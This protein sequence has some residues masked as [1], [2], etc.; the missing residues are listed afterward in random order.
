LDLGE[1]LDRGFRL[2]WKTIATTFPWLLLIVLPAQIVSV[3]VNRRP[4]GFQ[5]WSKNFQE[6]SQ[7]SPGSPPD[8]SGLNTALLSL[9]PLLLMALI[10]NLFAQGML[11]AFYTDR[12]LLR[13]TPIATCMRSIIGRLLPLAGV[14]LLSGLAGVAGIFMCCI[15]IFFFMT[16]L[17]VASQVCVVERAGAVQSLRR[18]WSLTEKRFWLM[19][20]LV[21]VTSLI[22]Q[23]VNV[24]FS[25][26]GTGIGGALSGVAGDII[27][28][29]FSTIGS[30]LA[31]GLGAAFLVFAYLDL[32]VRFER[33]DLGVIAAQSTSP[34]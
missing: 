6:Q 7:Q 28:V 12:I 4:G 18:S 22:T 25:T 15:G 16:R 33:L 27:T 10:T 1:V 11:T 19:L 9:L 8:L 17:A 21:L 5:Q 13:D 3:L 2:W 14:A 26:L 30:A 20:A 23:I 24:V 34:A 31:T 29:V 32:R